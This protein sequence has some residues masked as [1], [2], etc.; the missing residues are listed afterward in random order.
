MVA[1]QKEQ[2]CHS[3]PFDFAQS[4]LRGAECPKDS[5]DI[6]TS[7]NFHEFTHLRISFELCYQSLSGIM[8]SIR[9]VSEGVALG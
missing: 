2:T 1:V 8:K 3:E 7:R 5:F 6:P 9:S 4:K